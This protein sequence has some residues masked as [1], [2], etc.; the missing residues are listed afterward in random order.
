MMNVATFKI[1]ITGYES[2]SGSLS[3]SKVNSQSWSKSITGAQSRWGS[4]SGAKSV[5]RRS[6]S[7]SRSGRNSWTIYKSCSQ[8]GC[9]IV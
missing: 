2:K 4:S 6:V 3:G 7:G 8:S 5:S 9:K 1:S